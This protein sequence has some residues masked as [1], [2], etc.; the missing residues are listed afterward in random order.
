M[1]FVAMAQKTKCAYYISAPEGHD[2]TQVVGLRLNLN[3][4]LPGQIPL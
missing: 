4:S 2:K 1:V 3:F